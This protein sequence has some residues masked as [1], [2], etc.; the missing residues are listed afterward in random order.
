MA[1]QPRFAT[2]LTTPMGIFAA[3]RSVQRPNDYIRNLKQVGHLP[4]LRPG[5]RMPDLSDGSDHPTRLAAYINSLKTEN[6]RS[7]RFPIIRSE[8]GH[9]IAR[10]E[11]NAFKIRNSQDNADA[12]AIFKG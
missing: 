2:E 3:I 4:P 12:W 11:N 5:I 7:R 8:D 10:F 6:L 1:D 9:Y